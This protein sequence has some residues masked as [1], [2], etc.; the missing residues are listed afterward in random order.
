MRRAH[1]VLILSVFILGS[2]GDETHKMSYKECIV[3]VDSPIS[4]NGFGSVGADWI[5]IY[6]MQDNIKNNRRIKYLPGL[7]KISDSGFYFYFYETCPEKL[8]WSKYYID[9]FIK[10]LEKTYY[11][12]L[13]S[14]SP[15]EVDELGMQEIR[16]Y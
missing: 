12:K 15:Q 1:N 5:S 7:T 8:K 16:K 14:L 3:A 11:Y 6:M 9:N 2:C 10:A 4:K 13:K